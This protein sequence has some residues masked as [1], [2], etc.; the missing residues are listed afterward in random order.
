MQP[1]YNR[2]AFPLTV[3]PFGNRADTRDEVFCQYIISGRGKVP[4]KV[5]REEA[6]AGRNEREVIEK[7][8][9]VFRG[10]V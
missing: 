2:F 1:T 8:E 6:E 9:V 4:G 10:G 7:R 5:I 3:P